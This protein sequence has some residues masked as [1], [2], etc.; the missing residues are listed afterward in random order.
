MGSRRSALPSAITRPSRC[1]SWSY[2]MGG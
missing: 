1:T 2:L